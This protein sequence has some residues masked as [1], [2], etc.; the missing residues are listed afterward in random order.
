MDIIER[1][2]PLPLEKAWNPATLKRMIIVSGHYGSGKTNFALNLASEFA[3][4][5]EQVTLVDLDIVNPYFRSSDYKDDLDTLHVRLIAPTFANTTVEAPSLP[6]EISAAFMTQG[7]V[8]FDVGGDDA[9]ATALGRYREEFNDIDYDF[10]YVINARRNLTASAEEAIE[11]LGEI[12]SVC[13]LKATGIVNNTHLQEFTE[14]STIENSSD[15]AHG[16]EDAA[17]L[18]LVC[19]TLPVA[20]LD[21]ASCVNRLASA[22]G[23]LYP[24]QILVRPPWN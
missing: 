7:R 16:V 11:I 15:F 12:E 2:S 8:I 3:R 22:F 21:D 5:G 18:P 10:L 6:A 24:V 20:L 23:A 17:S 19:S 13:G 4:A 9:G 14:C 1:L